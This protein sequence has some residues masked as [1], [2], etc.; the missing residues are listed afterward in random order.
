MVLR[1]LNL[2][3]DY[4]CLVGLSHCTWHVL[5][6]DALLPVTFVIQIRSRRWVELNESRC[7]PFKRIRF[8]IKLHI[9]NQ[10]SIRRIV[11]EV[12]LDSLPT[13]YFL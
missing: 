8:D 10:S 12:S 1:L 11:E 5:D 2:F 13:T 3:I 7:G 4:E 9:K 6:S